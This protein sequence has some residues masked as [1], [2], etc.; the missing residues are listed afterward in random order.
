MARS[1]NNSNQYL[2]LASPPVTTTPITISF[3]FYPAATNDTYDA[4]FLREDVGTGPSY[5]GV[6]LNSSGSSAKVGAVTA[7]TGGTEFIAQTSTTFSANTWSHGAAVFASA[8]SRSAYLNGGGKITETTSATPAPGLTTLHVGGY[9]SGSTLFG[10]MNGRLAEI[11]IWDAALTDDEVI[12]LS[13]GV[14]P[15]R[16]RPQNLVAY[17]PLY[18]AASPEPNYVRNSTSLALTL[19]NAPPQIDH[20]PVMAPWSGARILSFVPAAAGPSGTLAVTEAADVAAFPSGTVA[21]NAALAAT[22]SADTASIA[23]LV[24]R[25]GT[26]AVTEA[27]D[28]ANIAGLVGRSGT[29]AA[30]ESADLSNT[31]DPTLFEAW[32]NFASGAVDATGHGNDG[33][34]HGTTLTTDPY[35]RAARS[36]NGSTDYIDGS[37]SPLEP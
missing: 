35:G 32:W 13:K 5:Y 8:T 28:V 20:A 24:G 36:F 7:N 10:P 11:G 27:A 3:W 18:G 31:V 16:V 1:F 15:L 12:S 14:S 25:S 6:Y 30:S 22:E 9:F 2:S 21:W 37:A 26:L 19:N 34:L 23:G 4:I 29:L 33:T 17:W